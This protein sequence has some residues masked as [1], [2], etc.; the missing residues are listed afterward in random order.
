MRMETPAWFEHHSE[1]QLHDVQ[2]RKEKWP[3]T[4]T[5]ALLSELIEVSKFIRQV[6]KLDFKFRIEFLEDSAFDGVWESF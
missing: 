3:N 5:Y 2:T 1:G 4:P 6:L